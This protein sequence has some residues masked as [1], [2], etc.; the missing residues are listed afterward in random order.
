MST[1]NPIFSKKIL[2]RRTT[3]NPG[4]GFILPRGLDHDRFAVMY[5]TEE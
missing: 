3:E 5:P 1:T 2:Q 4:A